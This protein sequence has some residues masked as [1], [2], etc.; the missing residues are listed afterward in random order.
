MKKRWILTTTSKIIR[1]SAKCLCCNEEIE[2][3]N[4]HDFKWCKCGNL[5]VDGG[6]DYL[7]RC[8]GHKG[9]I[10]ETSIFKDFDEKIKD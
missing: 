2:S 9:H 8:G 5:A 3:K 7:K 10:E 6:K 1:N 4:R